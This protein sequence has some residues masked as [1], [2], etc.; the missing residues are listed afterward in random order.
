[1]KVFKLEPHGK[2]LSSD[3]HKEAIIA[4]HGLY[5]GHFLY[6]SKMLQYGIVWY[7]MVLYGLVWYCMVLYGMVSHGMVWYGI[8]WYG[9][10]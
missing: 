5:N 4:L 3:R 2:S 1:M 6:P 8:V 9:L 10:V 7:G